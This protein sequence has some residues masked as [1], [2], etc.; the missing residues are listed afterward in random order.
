MIRENKKRK[1][2]EIMKVKKIIFEEIQKKSTDLVRVYGKKKRR[3]A[4]KTD[5]KMDTN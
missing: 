3:T 4:S 1:R 2:K 5:N